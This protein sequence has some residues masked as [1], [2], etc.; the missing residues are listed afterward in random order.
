MKRIPILALL[1]AFF[2]I[3][4]P[5]ASAQEA[6]AI[7]VRSFVQV[8][9]P[10]GWDIGSTTAKDVCTE[11]DDLAPDEACFLAVLRAERHGRCLAELAD[12]RAGLIGTAPRPDETGISETNPTPLCDPDDRTVTIEDVCLAGATGFTDEQGVRLEC[13]ETAQPDD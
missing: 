1:L 13:P 11:R 8:T 4:A 10:P 7:P 6:V 5:S 9:L 12:V 3:A 2:A